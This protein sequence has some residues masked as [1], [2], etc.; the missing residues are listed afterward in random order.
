MLYTFQISDSTPQS[1]SIINL[2]LALSEDYDFL[3]LI[4]TTENQAFCQMQTSE[5]SVNNE[6]S[7]NEI[8]ILDKCLSEYEQNPQK[9]KTWDE[10]EAE[11]IK[12]H[13]YE[14]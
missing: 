3:K 12:R 5:I 14:L 8:R 9:V 2:L 4:N 10:V 7:E 1:E 13:N 11:I 6:I